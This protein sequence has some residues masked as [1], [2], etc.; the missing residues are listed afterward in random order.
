MD[1][2]K[3]KTILEKYD[4]MLAMSFFMLTSALS[5]IKI[6]GIS[7]S[8]SVYNL[9]FTIIVPLFFIVILKIRI[10]KKNILPIAVICLSTIFNIIIGFTDLNTEDKMKEITY[11]I[12]L[13]VNLL[14][15]YGIIHTNEKFAQNYNFKYMNIA[16]LVIAI[17]FCI[18]NLI[19]N[20]NQ[21][22][23]FTNAQYRNH[24]NFKSFFANRNNFAMFLLF[25]IISTFYVLETTKYKKIVKFIQYFF[26]L[27][28]LLTLS[29][30]GVLALSVYIFSYL[31]LTNKKRKYIIA[32]II[33][34]IIVAI[35]NP[36]NVRGIISGFLIR[37]ETGSS[38]RVDLWK[39]SFTL[40][41]QKPFTGF[42]Y[43]LSG[44]LFKQ[45]TTTSNF[46][47]YYIKTIASHGMIGF[48][49]F[50]YLIIRL[51]NNNIY[52]YKND[53]KIGALCIA[54]LL[55]VLMYG[56]TEEIDL[57]SFG[58]LSLTITYFT[59]ILPI[60]YYNNM[61]RNIDGK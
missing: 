54:T 25:A 49:A 34:M 32:I 31:L 13:I 52:I 46:H 9:I 17:E 50:G 58:I 56:I 18:Y 1:N 51:L 2:S 29:R 27:N 28:L 35:V 45:I 53:N 15:I 40:I 30:S 38:G 24:I 16:V 4:K 48:I 3:E 10:N 41:S 59:F 47:N 11:A 19:V 21:F 22:T 42:G 8:L 14:M 60:Y 39:N 33:I 37:E 20:A 5:I 57:F 23:Y 44:N 26:I 12:S 7:T 43:T 61:R 6:L 36:L 55:A